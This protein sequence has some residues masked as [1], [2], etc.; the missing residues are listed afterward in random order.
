[1]T[2]RASLPSTH[3]R[4]SHQSVSFS[5]LRATRTQGRKWRCRLNAVDAP[6]EGVHRGF[7]AITPFTPL[8]RAQREATRAFSAFGTQLKMSPIGDIT[9]N[10]WRKWRNSR[11][12]RLSAAATPREG[13]YTGFYATYATCA[14]HLLRAQ[15]TV[16]CQQSHA[17]PNQTNA[18]NT[19]WR[20]ISSQTKDDSVSRG[21]GEI[22]ANSSRP[23]VTE[24]TVAQCAQVCRAW[25]V[26]G[27]R[28]RRLRVVA[29]SLRELRE[30]W[31]A[32]T[33]LIP[34]PSLLA[35]VSRHVVTRTPRSSH[36]VHLLSQEPQ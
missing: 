11:V 14:T 36:M 27:S 22:A 8:G 24:R 25:R 21:S 6:R 9:A 16:K 29:L 31:I 5:L 17:R 34:T 4:K 2:S 33:L 23:V 35:F 13:A 12:S 32:R 30:P 7:Y 15:S 20:S 28:F 18:R 10:E 19:G 3:N 1:M 26:S